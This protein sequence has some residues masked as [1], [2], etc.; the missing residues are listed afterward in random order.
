MNSGAP[1]F[2]TFLR[3]WRKANGLYKKEAAS[4][5]RI[6]LRTY[7][8]WEW[9]LNTPTEIVRYAITN[10]INELNTANASGQT[11]LFRSA[12]CPAADAHT[13]SSPWKGRR[14]SR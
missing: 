11:R 8:N 3:A 4:F 5:L 2:G 10:R 12:L 6:P 1:D 14:P 7:E 9:G 13:P